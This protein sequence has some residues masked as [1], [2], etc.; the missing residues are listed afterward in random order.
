VQGDIG[1]DHESCHGV[2]FGDQT[3]SPESMLVL[4]PWISHHTAA[5]TLHGGRLTLREHGAALVSGC[6]T[7]VTGHHTVF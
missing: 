2:P 7:A 3:G 1:A 4:S 5:A 6:A